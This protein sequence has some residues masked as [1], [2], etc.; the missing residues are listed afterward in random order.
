MHRAC[1]ATAR[2]GPAA[3]AP[4]SPLTHPGG[5][6]RCLHP[7]AQPQ[8]PGRGV[9]PS[10]HLAGTRGLCPGGH[11]PRASLAE[12]LCY[13]GLGRGYVS[14]VADYLENAWESRRRCGPPR[15]PI[16][17]RQS[18]GQEARP[19]EQ[20]ADPAQRGW[21][22]PRVPGLDPEVTNSSC[23]SIAKGASAG[24]TVGW[25]TPSRTFFW[26]LGRSGCWPGS[27][28]SA[29]NYARALGRPIINEL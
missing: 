4:G 17:V 28:G 12:P 16:C 1:L 22:G 21:Q 19:G 24:G 5:C 7:T 20:T 27:S 9:A 8:R 10:Q 14:I 3:G 18:L 26:L 29:M 25:A 6:H 23:S 15:P 13:T 2:R 11:V